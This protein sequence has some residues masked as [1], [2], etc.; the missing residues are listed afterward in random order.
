M[1]NRCTEKI[2]N[3]QQQY[4]STVATANCLWL[5]V[6]ECC[7]HCTEA[8]MCKKMKIGTKMP[9]SEWQEAAELLSKVHTCA[10]HM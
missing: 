2:R 3:Q 4:E 10:T 5:P 7:I 8:N 1:D 6:K 9:Q